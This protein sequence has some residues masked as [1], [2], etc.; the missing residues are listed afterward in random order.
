M[1]NATIQTDKYRWKITQTEDN[2][3]FTILYSIA[4]GEEE[5]LDDYVMTDSQIAWLMVR[6]NAY[7]LMCANNRLIKK[8]KMVA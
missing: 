6:V 4:D 1:N 5:Y 7:N 8:E 3:F 2:E